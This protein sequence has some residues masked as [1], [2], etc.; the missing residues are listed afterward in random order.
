MCVYACKFH[1][2]SLRVNCVEYPH[3]LHTWNIIL[4]AWHARDMIYSTLCGTWSMQSC[5]MAPRIAIH[6]YKNEVTYK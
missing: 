2:Q 4:H 1:A 6:T 3:V 5:V